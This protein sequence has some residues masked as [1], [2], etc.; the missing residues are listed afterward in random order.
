[1]AIPALRDV[2]FDVE[3]GEI[4]GMV[5]RPGAGKSTLLLCLAGLLR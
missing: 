5:G 2:S 1:M 4:V 3:A